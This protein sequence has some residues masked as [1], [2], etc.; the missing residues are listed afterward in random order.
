MRSIPIVFAAVVITTATAACDYGL[1]V[2]DDGPVRESPRGLSLKDPRDGRTLSVTWTPPA[3]GGLTALRLVRRADEPPISATDANAEVVYEGGELAFLDGEDD[4]TPLALGT[5][6]HYALYAAY[7]D[8]FSEPVRASEVLSAFL[9]P[10]AFAAQPNVD[11]SVSLTWLLPEPRGDVVAA[12]VSREGEVI[13]D[14]DVNGT[15]DF[16]AAPG[17]PVTYVL[18]SKDADG[19]LSSTLEQTITP[20]FDGSTVVRAA[21]GVAS[22]IDAV[23]AVPLA[24]GG[25]AVIGVSVAAD[26]AANV[27]GAAIPADPCR[28]T[29]ALVRI[30]PAGAQGTLLARFEHHEDVAF[31]DVDGGGCSSSI[32]DIDVQDDGSILVTGGFANHVYL[33]GADGSVVDLATFHRGRLCDGRACDDAFIARVEPNGHVA[34]VSRIGRTD[35]LA[36]EGSRKIAVLDEDT[37]VLAGAIFERDPSPVSFNGAVTNVPAGPHGFL[38]RFALSTGALEAPVL[39]EGVSDS[40]G[41]I[42]V[43]AVDAHL[44]LALEGGSAP[45]VYGETAV[46]AAYQN[47]IVSLD[48]QLGLEWAATVTGELADLAIEADGVVIAGAAT[49]GSYAPPAGAALPVG[50]S[51][52]DDGYILHLGLDGA[53]RQLIPF[54]TGADDARVSTVTVR[55]DGDLDVS[56]RSVGHTSFGAPGAERFLD[57]GETGA[58]VARVAVDGNIRF[59]R[60]VRGDLFSITGLAALPADNTFVAGGFAGPLTLFDGDDAVAL[61]APENPFASAPTE[62][63]VAVV[64]E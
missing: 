11:G 53:V 18:A 48:H 29:A 23:A 37:A 17:I 26:T 5:E 54:G 6:Y 2:D 64:T 56:G 45:I 8:D 58:Y 59:V 44:F 63:F 9:P 10:S 14:G 7:G 33:G 41:I 49:A 13:F 51:D 35:Y 42:D 31:G 21:D 32:D 34:W 38:V 30:D 52:D 62:G 1:A 20:C 55:P 43:E 12:V 61:D 15:I 4:E 39:I 46:S 19:A 22:S 24:A 16:G 28:A 47:P 25:G 57:N 60:P 40:G 50:G 27:L 36:N 3:Q